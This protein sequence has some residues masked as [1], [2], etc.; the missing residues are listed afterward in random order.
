MTARSY[1]LCLFLLLVFF[2]IRSRESSNASCY[3]SQSLAYSII[4]SPLQ[5]RAADMGS[6]PA[7]LEG[8]FHVSIRFYESDNSL[9]TTNLFRA[10]Q[11]TETTYEGE[12]QWISFAVEFLDGP[13]SEC[14]AQT[15]NGFTM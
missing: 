4:F 1:Y 2:N 11:L 5:L 7:I 3:K 12:T 13:P 10:R 9:R 8:L 14:F 6:V 15:I